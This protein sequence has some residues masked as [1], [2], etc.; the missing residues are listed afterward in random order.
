MSFATPADHPTHALQMT[1]SH[2]SDLWLTRSAP[3]SSSASSPR[4][5]ARSPR[6]RCSPCSPTPGREHRRRGPA[7]HVAGSRPRSRPRSGTGRGA[8]ASAAAARRACC[9][10]RSLASACAPSFVVLLSAQVPLVL[11]VAGLTSARTLAAAEWVPQEHRMRTLSSV[12]G[13]PPAWIV[14]CPWSAS[15]MPQLR[16]GWIALRS[17]RRSSPLWP[18]WVSSGTRDE[19]APA[20]GGPSRRG[21]ERP[22]PRRSSPSRVR[23]SPV[24]RSCTRAEAR[25]RA[26]RLERVGGRPAR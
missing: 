6:H 11:G 3:P 25:R 22:S 2:T 19:A 14:A 23:T 15:S 1:C 4:R 26:S 9:S 5:R 12:V 21:R 24:E 20:P 8:P 13:Q 10:S 7:P 16:L 17:R 18:S